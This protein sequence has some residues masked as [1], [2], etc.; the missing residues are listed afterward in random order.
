MKNVVEGFSKMSKSD[1]IDWLVAHFL[2]GDQ[3]TKEEFEKFW[4]DDV[5]LQNTIDGFSENV[6]SNHILPFSI[7]PNFLIND[8]IY[9]IPMV[10]EESSVVAA[11]SSAAKFWLS[12]GGFKSEVISTTKVGHVHFRWTGN[13]A[14]FDIEGDSILESVKQDTKPLTAS[15]EGRGGGIQ[16]INFKSLSDKVDNIYQ[17]EVHFETCDS[18]GANF[19][20]TVLEQIAASLRI[21][22]EEREYDLRY[23]GRL[24]IIMSILSNY[25]PQCLVRSWVSCTIDELDPDMPHD[26]TQHLAHRFKTAV[27]IAC[28]DPFRAVT[29]NKGIFNGIDALVLATGNDFRAIE[30]CGHAYASKDGQYRS[31]ST[32]SIMNDIFE[33][34]LE[35]PVACGTVGGLTHLHPMSKIAL[36]VLGEPSSRELMQLMCTLGLAQNFAAVKS[37]V[38]TGIQKGHMKMHLSNILNHLGIEGTK[39]E[40][41][42][43]Y[44]SDKTVSFSA[45]KDYAATLD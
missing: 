34:S 15:M 37:L 2:N 31:L 25:T 11:A 43:N 33:F 29:H 32:C 4:L 36:Q 1:K 19:I 45:V 44:F 38:T 17:V 18:M 35:I 27:D 20:N 5:K 10:I 12:R 23:Q 41:V 16:K 14:V 30:A 24:E 13:P 40:S 28:N 39:A 22:F 3:S 7:A 42:K 26:I 6:L 21:I 8:K 9:A